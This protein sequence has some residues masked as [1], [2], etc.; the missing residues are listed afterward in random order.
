MR[1]KR[2]DRGEY[3]RGEAGPRQVDED[4]RVAP[5]EHE[6]RVGEVAR[7][8]RLRHLEEEDRVH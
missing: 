5:L 7:Q 4:V 8:R 2:T 6:R 1:A 3:G